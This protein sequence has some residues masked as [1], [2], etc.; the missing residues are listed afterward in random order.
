MTPIERAREAAFEDVAGDEL[1]ESSLNRAIDAFLASLSAQG[2]VIPK[3]ASEWRAIDSAPRDGTFID[4]W[5]IDSAGEGCRVAGAYWKEP[6]GPH[7]ARGAGWYG[8][9]NAEGRYLFI[10]PSWRVANW[11]PLPAPPSPHSID[12][13]QSQEP[14]T[15]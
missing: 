4:L 8:D 3:E 6:R 14:K 9:A 7:D 12:P 11:M 10:E 2:L 1:G 13:H 15:D 5:V